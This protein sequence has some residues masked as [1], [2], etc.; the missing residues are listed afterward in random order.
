MGNGPS[1]KDLDFTLLEGQ[2]CIGMNRIHRHQAYKDGWR[3]DVYVVADWYYNPR[4]RND[5]LF[6]VEQGYPVWT[7]ETILLGV[8]EV[9]KIPSWVGWTNINILPDCRHD[10]V[11]QRPASSWHDPYICSYGGSMN[12]SIQIATQRLGFKE[13][14]LLGCDQGYIPS[15]PGTPDPNHFDPQY[16]DGM[17]LNVAEE[18]NMVQDHVWHIVQNEAASRGFRVVN[19]TPGGGLDLFVRVS[20]QEMTNDGCN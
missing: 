2:F 14:V 18:T 17:P 7:R 19:A 9:A 3:P 16:M 11:R 1:L 15:P 8:C 10:L 13:V 6:H 20:L 4:V 12:A 5:T